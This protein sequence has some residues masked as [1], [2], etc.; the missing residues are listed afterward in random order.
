VHLL[1]SPFHSWSIPSFTSPPSFTVTYTPVM[2]RVLLG[3]AACAAIALADSTCNMHNEHP[4]GCHT[5]RKQT[6][7]NPTHTLFV[8]RLHA[9]LFY[10]PSL[11]IF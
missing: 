3:L 6:S 9:V 2:V 5:T 1:I 8:C 11:S 7:P 10:L 4:G